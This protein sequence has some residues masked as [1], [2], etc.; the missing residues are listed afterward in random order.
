MQNQTTATLWGFKNY[1]INLLSPKLLLS[2]K[3][4]IFARIWIISLS[5]QRG[6]DWEQRKKLLIDNW[7]LLETNFFY[8]SFSIVVQLISKRNQKTRMA[9]SNG[10]KLRRNTKTGDFFTYWRKTKKKNE[11]TT[12]I[13]MTTTTTETPRR[14]RQ[15]RRM[16]DRG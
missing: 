6:K 11:K 16:N 14:R 2:T 10:E 5:T 3:K 8:A 4:V 12:T 9:Q 1:E 7:K 13:T 15:R